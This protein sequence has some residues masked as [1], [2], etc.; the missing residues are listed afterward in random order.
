MKAKCPWCSHEH[1]SKDH[2][3]NWY[4][5]CCGYTRLVW[6][7]RPLRLETVEEDHSETETI[8]SI[9]TTPEKLTISGNI[10]GIEIYEKA[11]S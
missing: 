6:L 9:M 2:D 4:F 11:I 8:L 1:D 3:I 7:N 10:I 5:V